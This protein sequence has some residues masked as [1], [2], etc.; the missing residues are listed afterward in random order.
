MTSTY[1][2]VRNEIKYTGVT[3]FR[4]REMSKKGPGDLF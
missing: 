3:A 2:D 4:G 1:P